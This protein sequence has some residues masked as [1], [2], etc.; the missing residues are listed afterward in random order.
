MI[1]ALSGF[2]LIGAIVLVG[3]GVGRWG[4]LPVQAEP[5]LGRLV[6]AVLTPCLLFTVVAAADLHVLLSEPLLVS[7]AA[8]FTCF[9]LFAVALRRMDRGSRILGALAGGYVNANYVG[10]P[11]ATYVL[12]DAALVVPI[13]MLQLLLVT[14]VALTLVE[15]ASTGRLPYGPRCRRR[16]GTR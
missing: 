9:A 13:V 3:W 11:V 15:I 10:I 2:A 1:S 14:P 16:R 12:G 8:S 6:Y 7:A 5:I 4:V